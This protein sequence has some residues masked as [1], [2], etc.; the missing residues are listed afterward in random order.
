MCSLQCRK[1]VGHLCCKLYCFL[2]LEFLE[3]QRQN[4]VL[5]LSF[6]QPDCQ[7]PRAIDD[8]CR[9]LLLDTC[10]SSSSLFS[11]FAQLRCSLSDSGC[12]HQERSMY[13]ATLDVVWTWYWPEPSHAPS[14]SLLA[15]H[16]LH[17]FLLSHTGQ[18]LNSNTPFT[19]YN[20]LSYQLYNRFDNRD[21]RTAIVRSTVLNEQPR[22]PLFVQPGWTNT[23]CS[24][25]RLSNRV[26]QPV[27]Q[28]AAHT[29]Q[30]V[31]KPVSQP[32][33]KPVV[34]WIQT[35]NLLSNPFDNRFDNRLYR[36]NGA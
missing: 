17:S 7:S 11:I 36:V 20:R 3:I 21:E 6:G 15:A 4:A 27:W 30:P 35:F 8:L 31:V 16:R 9:S 22:Q 23:H 2:F 10:D 14:R 12:C 26:V 18:C 32:V 29:I 34:L 33:W 13:T 1:P 25:N 24:F 19:R 5:S 28:L